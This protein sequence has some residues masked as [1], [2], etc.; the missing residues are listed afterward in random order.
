MSE[1]FKFRCHECLR[2]CCIFFSL[3]LVT[4]LLD[5]RNVFT[6]FPEVV[7]FPTQDLKAISKNPSMSLQGSSHTSDV[8]R[9]GWG[10]NTH[11]KPLIHSWKVPVSH[12]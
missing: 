9:D 7:S 5:I 12:K 3:S 8:R 11:P 2:K 1:I 10:R 6:V 4:L